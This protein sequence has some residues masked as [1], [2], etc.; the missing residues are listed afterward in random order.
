MKYKIKKPFFKLSEQK[1]YIVGDIIELTDA[2]AL[3]LVGYLK[4]ADVST[5]I[6]PAQADK[7]IKKSNKKND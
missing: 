7:I 2:E 3:P 6:T 4:D 5:E 1:N